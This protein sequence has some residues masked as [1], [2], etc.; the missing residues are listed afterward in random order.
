M[1]RFD[2]VSKGYRTTQGQEKVILANCAF[3]FPSGKKTGLLG[4]NGAGKST[5]LK[6]IAGTQTPDD[7]RVVRDGSVSWPI[8]YAGSFHRDLTGAQNTRFIAR[9]YGVDTDALCDFVREF[10]E[11]GAYFDHPLRNYS[12]GMRARLAFGVS[13]GI[14]FDTY[15]VDEVTSVGDARFRQKCADVFE[16]RLKDAAAIIVSHSLKMIAETC[17]MIAVLDQGR[18]LRFDDVE[19]GIGFHERS[20]QV[21]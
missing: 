17:D 1:V 10:S 14:Q 4:R 11:L 12:S 7:G 2:H 13:M 5:V 15:L 18:L 16:T 9:V 19:E 8:G 20:M 3:S 6:I 21:G